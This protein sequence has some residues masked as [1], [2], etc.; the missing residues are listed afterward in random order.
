MWFVGLNNVTY[1]F[2]EWGVIMRACLD[3]R[4]SRQLAILE[5]LWD[6]EWMTSE[7]LAER[8]GNSEK[9]IRT[10]IPIINKY[11]YP[12]SIETSFKLGIFLKKDV[13]IPKSYIYAAILNESSE[14]DLLEQIFFADNLKKIDLS[15]QLYTSESQITR[16]LSKINQ[17][18]ENYE[19]RIDNALQINGDEQKI[20]TF[21]SCFFLEKYG[22]PEKKFPYEQVQ[23]IDRLIEDFLKENIAIVFANSK[24]H[25][26]L[27]R[28]KFQ[29]LISIERM[30]RKHEIQT[31]KLVNGFS[32][33]MVEAS[34]C[35]E[36]KAIFGLEL[37]SH[38]LQQL[39]Q[40]YFYPFY[41]SRVKQG[42]EELSPLKIKNKIE[43]I[44]DEL[45]KVYHVE[46]DYRDKIVRDIYWTTFQICGPTY[47]LHD[48]KKEF[49]EGIL[50][51]SPD[52]AQFL[53]KKFQQIFSEVELFKQRK[54]DE[55]VHQAIFELM[56]SW[57][58]LRL[59]VRQ[60]TITVT[61]A[62]MLDT[63]YEH[64]K[65]V[66]EEIEFY[67]RHKIK[68]DIID[69]YV[70]LDR[71]NFSNYDCLLTDTYTSNTYPIPTIGI[72]NYLNDDT[73]SKLLDFVYLKREESKEVFAKSH[74]NS[75]GLLKE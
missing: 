13:T 26:S 64:M 50:A 32:F 2:I 24:Q 61:A 47:I 27:S 15:E 55:M 59:G 49:F 33:L 57:A 3:S 4:L 70:K 38:V 39:F 54:V 14:Y 20:R 31:E 51:D 37:T 28:L 68:I 6:S 40:E 22:S 46:C 8:T 45:S 71:A 48:K 66:K 23:V 12:L 30:K 1:L 10:D 17:S 35:E 16:W 56:T 41:P 69:P 67:F 52:L 73:I 65:M 36:F 75:I 7:E 21:F 44:I 18:L 63:T 29:L 9:A 19:L 53:H 43:E 25:F 60:S 42:H 58:S 5:T 11:I 34:L 74:L 72:S 62:L